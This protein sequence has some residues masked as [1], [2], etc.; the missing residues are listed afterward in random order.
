[1]VSVDKAVIARLEKGGKHFE[2]LVDPELAYAFREGKSVS[3]NEMLAVDE[4]FKDARKGL[5]IS[6]QDLLDT[7]KTEDI[8]EIAKIIL[9]EGDIQLTT[10]FRRKK[11][12]EKKRQ[13]AEFISKNSVDPQT[14]NP[15]PPERI[16]NAME[17]AKVHIDV[18]KSIEEQIDDVVKA[19]RGILPISFEK[20]RIE[21]KI[22]SQY[23]GR[24]Y[25][26]IKSIGVEPKW[27]SDGSLYA[28]LEIPAGLRESLYTKINNITHGD[29]VIEEKK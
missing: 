17:Q 23:S 10:E 1:M 19:I 26:I 3:F 11:L 2:I 24:A 15:H 7:F 4:V 27:Q 5:P 6:R 28:I 9:K 16:I 12:E 25:G 20:I 22:P 18:F 8:N 29:C 14:K 21:V 13:I